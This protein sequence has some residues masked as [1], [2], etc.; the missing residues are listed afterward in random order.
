[1]TTTPAPTEIDLDAIRARLLNATDGPWAIWPDLRPEGLITIG[2]A[3]GVIPEGEMWTDGPSNT[4]AHVYTDEDADFIV[5]APEDIRALLDAL[6]TERRQSAAMASITGKA[7]RQIAEE[8]DAAREEL[9]K[10]RAELDERGQTF[11]TLWREFELNS[12]RMEELTEAQ[13]RLMQWAAA[14]LGTSLIHKRI[15][16]VLGLDASVEA[17]A[18]A[19]AA[20][21]DV[22]ASGERL[23]VA[24]PGTTAEP[25]AREVT[26]AEAAQQARLNLIEAEQRRIATAEPADDER[27]DTRHPYADDRCGLLGP[28]LGLFCQ[29]RPGHTGGH[30]GVDPVEGEERTWP[31]PQA[32]P[33][34]QPKADESWRDFTIHTDWGNEQDVYVACRLDDVCEEVKHN[35]DDTLL[36]LGEAVDWAKEHAASPFHAEPAAG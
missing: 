13:G 15:R 9:A 21:N 2:D 16:E 34:D 32:E 27:S 10:T 8:R 20:P 25:A 28:A 14:E 36:T 26:L 23:Y 24:N 18:A 1:M 6:A 3:T 19:Q 29:L 31:N 7:I 35:P 30:R 11:K 33:A 4:V 12:K 17:M 22:N 5:H